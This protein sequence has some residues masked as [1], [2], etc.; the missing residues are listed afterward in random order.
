[1]L[2]R[3]TLDVPRTVENVDVLV[4][5]FDEA[6]ELVV[7]TG[8]DQ[9]FGINTIHWAV[10]SGDP[11][12]SRCGSDFLT[13]VAGTLLPVRCR[14]SATGD[15]TGFRHCLRCRSSRQRFEATDR[16]SET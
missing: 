15:S 11:R 4:R 12:S 14:F 8:H 13:L 3:D 6:I 9:A 5:L 10:E 7:G 2:S 1:M 16:N